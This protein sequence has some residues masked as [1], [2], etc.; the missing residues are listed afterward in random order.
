MHRDRFPVR[1]LCWAASHSP[2][3]YYA[4]RRRPESGRPGRDAQLAQEIARVR[5]G[6]RAAYG[7]RKV[8]HA[9]RRR[10]RTVNRKRIARVMAAEGWAGVPRRH[11][12]QTPAVRLISRFENLVRRR[13]V[14]SRPNQLWLG[15]M[16]EFLTRD[17]KLFLASLLDAFSGQVVGYAFGNHPTSELACR[18]L[19][20]ARRWRRPTRG[21]LLHTDQGS[22]YV[23][24]EYQEVAR[25]LGA[26][27][28]WSAPGTPADNARQESFHSLLKRECLSGRTTLSRAHAR[29]EVTRW[30][31]FYQRHRLHSSLGYLSPAE[32]E[33]HHAA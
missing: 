27:S 16:T 17:G 2:S 12:R 13:F 32:Y 1:V 6:Y 30:I 25:E 9:L 28:S 4:R 18:A 3:T 26:T 11:I 22:P 31:R 8:V 10:G 24:W 23:A 33:R 15:D 21:L 14:A 7:S 19:E 20:Q 5:R 29:E